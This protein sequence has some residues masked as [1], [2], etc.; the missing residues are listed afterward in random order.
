MG[1]LIRLLV[2]VAAFGLV[3]AAC[4]DSDDGDTGADTSA[5]TDTETE[6]PTTDDTEASEEPATDADDDAAQDFG[7]PVTINFGH[8]FPA[9]HPIQAGALEQWAADVSDATDGTVTVEFFAGGSLAPAP[10]TYENVVAG[11]QD[12]GWALQ[13]YTPGRF[14]VTDVIE[15]PFTF[16]SAQQA[17]DVLW[18]LYE[19]FPEFQAE[20]ADVKLLGMWV[21][22]LGD[23]WIAEGKVESLDDIDGLTLRAPSPVQNAVIEALGGN[24]VGLPAPELFDSLERGVIDGLFIANSGLSSFNLYE[25][26]ESGVEC[27]CYVAAQFLVM[28]LDTW[29]SLSPAQQAAVEEISGR[30]LSTNAAVVYDGAYDAAA[31]RVVESGI[32]KVQLSDAELDR[33][34]EAT[35]SVIDDWISS[36]S[37]DFPTQEMYDR[38]LELSAS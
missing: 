24:P 32:E 5:A 4:G 23:L 11:A 27:N 6:A 8:P 29:N 34:K 9:Q 3:A 19:E 21:H 16:T 30:N 26:L 18:T 1:K 12:V 25:V 15:M 13:G 17:T 10:Q 38:M 28:N 31:A 36:N 22:D 2:V 33:W 35:Q 37:A 20:Y 14:P 7:D